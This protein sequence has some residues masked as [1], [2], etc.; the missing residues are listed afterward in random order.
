MTGVGERESECAEMAAND[1]L[2]GTLPQAAAWVVFREMA[3]V[4]RFSQPARDDWDA[5][6]AYPKMRTE[7]PERGKSGELFDALRKGRLRAF[8]RRN[9]PA[10]AME[11]IPDIEWQDLIV[12]I[13][14]PYRRLET[15]VQEIPWHDIRVKRAEVEKLWRRPS[16]IE[17][18][19]RYPKAWFQARY[20]ELRSTHPGFSQNEL[21]ELLQLRFQNKNRREPPSRT[22][23]QRYLKEL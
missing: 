5:F 13:D 3:V 16:E 14:G 17:G 6:M 18:R 4:D 7:F 8:G 19:S 22:T 12:D 9:T 20:A 15:G 11:E 21:I 2:Y 23:I 1:E 10:A